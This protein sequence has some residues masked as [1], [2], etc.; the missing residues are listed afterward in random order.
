MNC[1]AV[2]AGG[3]VARESVRLEGVL[4]TIK[5][6]ARKVGALIKNFAKRVGEVVAS[7]ASNPDMPE[8]FF[9]TGCYGRLCM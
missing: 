6:Q 8:S 4:A 2:M 3:D 9:K 7:T 1:L 5:E